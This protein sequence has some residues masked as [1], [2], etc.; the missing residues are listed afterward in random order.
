MHTI[1][2]CSGV[3]LNRVF[4]S[5]IIEFVWIFNVI[6]IF[7]VESILSKAVVL[8]PTYPAQSRQLAYCQTG[9]GDVGKTEESVSRTQFLLE[10]YYA[11]LF[12]WS[13]VKFLEEPESG[14]LTNTGTRPLSLKILDHL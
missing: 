4:S 13:R 11:I 14:C 3:H 9:H 2:T 12:W 7:F 6:R 1:S 8:A 10:R 5:H